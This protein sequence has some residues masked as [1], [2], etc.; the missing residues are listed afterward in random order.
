MVSVVSFG[1]VVD[2]VAVIEGSGVALGCTCSWGAVDGVEVL[3]T[4]LSIT[5]VSLLI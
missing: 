4:S 5:S 3:M 2:G 1:R